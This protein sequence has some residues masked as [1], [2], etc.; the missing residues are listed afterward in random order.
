MGYFDLTFDLTC[1]RQSTG[2][3]GDS[4][5]IKYN[6]RNITEKSIITDITKHI[7]ATFET[8]I[9]IQNIEGRYLNYM[10]HCTGAVS[11]SSGD[12]LALVLWSREYRST[13]AN[14]HG[15]LIPAD[16]PT[17]IIGGNK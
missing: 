9:T 10:D 3:E 14:Y 15:S 11:D 4:L 13:G 7:T 8:H 16:I 1:S 6:I 12:V 17:R 2:G 5:V